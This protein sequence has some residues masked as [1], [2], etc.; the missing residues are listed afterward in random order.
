MSP[1]V[2]EEPLIKRLARSRALHTR[3]AIHSPTKSQVQTLG[4]PKIF[5]NPRSQPWIFFPLRL[6]FG[7]DG[8][9]CVK[10][11]PKNP[12][13]VGYI[14]SSRFFVNFKLLYL[15]IFF[16]VYPLPVQSC[17]KIQ[18]VDLGSC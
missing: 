2:R 6:D 8:F 10:I 7:F 4:F 17:E 3:H 13:G 14:F 15:V 11:V 12:K 16:S 1:P 5:S 18:V 9:F